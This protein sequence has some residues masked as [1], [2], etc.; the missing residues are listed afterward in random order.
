MNQN[1]Q[2]NGLHALIVRYG[3]ECADSG[4]GILSLAVPLP[5]PLVAAA[6]DALAPTAIRNLIEESNNG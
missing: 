3:L 5:L 2:Q 1:E 6:L 4:A